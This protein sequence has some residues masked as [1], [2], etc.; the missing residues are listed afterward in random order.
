MKNKPYNSHGTFFFAPCYM[1]LDKVNNYV[2]LGV[3]MYI[4]DNVKLIN[5]QQK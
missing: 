2:R 3:Y 1:N 5:R 4:E